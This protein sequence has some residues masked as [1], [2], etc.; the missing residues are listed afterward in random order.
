MQ[1]D[2]QAFAA[3]IERYQHMVF[4]LA[5]KIVKNR[6]DA[7]EVA[8][9]VFINAFRAL[10]NYKG[11][12]KFSTWLYKI[13]YYKSL[14]YVKRNKSQPETLSIDISGIYNIGALDEALESMEASDRKSIIRKAMDQL[15]AADSVLITLYYFESLSLEE[16]S[17]IMG[18]SANTAK[19]RLFRGRKRLAD[20]L[21]NHLDLEMIRN[22]ERG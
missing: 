7:E 18:I 3:L 17:V 5:L 14:D 13:A 11:D 2:N 21:K 8:Q 12:A 22:Y 16:I 10:R 15:P 4:T 19:V 6:E 20:I 9:D 1:G